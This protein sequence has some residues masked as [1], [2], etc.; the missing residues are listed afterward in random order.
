MASGG[1]SVMAIAAT[2]AKKDEKD[3]L[4]AEC[5]AVIAEAE[6]RLLGNSTDATEA[7]LMRLVDDHERHMDRETLGLNAGT[8]VM[9]PRAAALLARSLGNRPSL[10]YPGDKYEMGMEYAEQIEVVAEGL[11][12]RLFGAPFA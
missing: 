12:K 2:E 7:Q 10:G 5:R 4:P 9:N 1:V 11:V 8:N 3:W 6:E